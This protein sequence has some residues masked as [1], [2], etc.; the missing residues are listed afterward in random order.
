MELSDF[1]TTRPPK[2]S[3]DVHGMLQIMQG[4]KNKTRTLHGRSTRHMDVLLC[5]VGAVAFYLCYRFWNTHEFESFT[6]EDW[7]DN[8]KWFD[9]KL[10]IDIQS[11][12][13]VKPMRNCSCASHLKSVLKRLRMAICKL[14]HL[15]R[16][17][18]AKILEL[19]EEEDEAIRRMG[20]WNPSVY[21]NSYST[22]LPMSPIRKL[23]G[24]GDGNSLH[25][26][27]RSA[28]LPSDELRRMTPFAW[29]YDAC[30]GTL[31]YDSSKYT[32]LGFLRFMKEIND[33]LLQDAAATMLLHEERCNHPL[34]EDIPVFSSDQ[35]LVFKEEMK[36]AL[37]SETCPRDWM[38]S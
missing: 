31:E 11:Q 4:K 20:N 23:A 27:A 10:L 25:Y 37:E 28:V 1:L 9:V 22:K 36:N 18:G 32:A 6:V 3:I 30:D 8:S 34:F 33:I 35:F 2:R 19:M 29:C 24:F 16:H 38:L 15:G 26:N 5:C 7:C 17:I 12:S 13:H 14:L 21:D